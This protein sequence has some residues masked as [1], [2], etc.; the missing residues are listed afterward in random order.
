MSSDSGLSFHV[1]D[2]LSIRRHSG[3][4]FINVWKINELSTFSFLDAS[5]KSIWSGTEA[6]RK[7]NLDVIW[8]ESP[9][10]RG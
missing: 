7:V 1:P 9:S 5:S 8:V 10:K 3:N 4:S 6:K 2:D